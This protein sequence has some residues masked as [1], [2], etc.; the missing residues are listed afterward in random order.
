[1]RQVTV[2]DMPHLVAGT[3]AAHIPPLT[4]LYAERVNHLAI[5]LP[6]VAKSL[7]TLTA[8]RAVEKIF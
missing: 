7:V 4:R 5:G 8:K 2:G 3:G 6:A 1:M